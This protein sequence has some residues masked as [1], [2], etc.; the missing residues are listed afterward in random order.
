M[1]D[2]DQME[3]AP[4]ALFNKLLASE[5]KTTDM[6]EQ[7]VGKRLSVKVLGQQITGAFMLRESVLYTEELP[8]IV[9]HNFVVID[10]DHIPQSLYELIVLKQTGI[11]TA[12]NRLKLD[13]WRYV[14]TYGWIK[15]DDAV[16]FAGNRI[17]LQCAKGERFVPYKRY[18][19]TFHPFSTPGMQ[20]IEYFNPR[21]VHSR[22]VGE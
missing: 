1:T 12:M 15:K 22:K 18:S 10:P 7:W 16:D 9:S 14:S 2:Q 4:V 8:F 20:L 17:K 5:E 6:L 13:S 11:G 19:I 21:L 3:R